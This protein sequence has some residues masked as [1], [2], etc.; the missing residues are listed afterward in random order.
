M[1]MTMML[2]LPL[3]TAV[4]A[5]VA[6]CCQIAFCQQSSEGERTP[7]LEMKALG[8]DDGLVELTITNGNSSIAIDL[9]RHSMG[10]VPCIRI[11]ANDV[12]GVLLTKNQPF[13]DGYW[14]PVALESTAVE[15]GKYHNDLVTLAPKATVMFRV[16]IPSML[17]GVDAD[18]ARVE[19]ITA[20]LVYYRRDRK[21]E[22]TL[23][24]AIIV[25]RKLSG[26][27]GT[28][29]DGKEKGVGSGVFS[30]FL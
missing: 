4:A 22:T 7:I 26:K 3:M 25:K 30:L 8:Q 17:I 21:A 11:K 1:T 2:R 5:L 14:T 19:T 16:S 28:S 12:N 24:Q 13:P 23:S 9:D 15:E 29:K 10:V 20:K 18:F 6:T 27:T